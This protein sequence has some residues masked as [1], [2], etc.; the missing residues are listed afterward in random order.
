MSARALRVAK[1]IYIWNYSS[2]AS[3]VCSS[4]LCS[5]STKH[6]HKLRTL[7]YLQARRRS[8]KVQTRF[9]IKLHTGLTYLRET[10]PLGV[11]AYD[12]SSNR[13]LFHVKYTEVR[14]SVVMSALEREIRKNSMLRS[15]PSCQDDSARWKSHSGVHGPSFTELCVLGYL[16][17]YLPWLHYRNVIVLVAM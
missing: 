7:A 10:R 4:V 5:W 14:F 16:L 3:L 9:C 17:L 8:S 15:R 2:Y 11:S 6:L 13:A 1:R 12:K